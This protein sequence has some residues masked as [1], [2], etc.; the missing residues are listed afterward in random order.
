MKHAGRAA[1]AALFGFVFL[2]A[3][4]APPPRVHPRPYGRGK[5][6]LH[7][8]VI[9]PYRFHNTRIRL[10]FDFAKGIV[11]GDVTNT[12]SPKTNSLSVVPFNSVGPVF[13]SVTL[14][15]S[16]VKYHVTSDHLYVRLP[17]PAKAS[18]TLAIEAKYTVKPVRG[19]YFIRPDKYYPNYQP[20]IWSQGEAEDNRFWFP[21]WDEP[22][23]KTPVEQ[24]ITVPSGW[25][26]IANGHLRTYNAA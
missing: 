10:S 12:I 11:Y 17:H 13:H 26:V 2:A 22:N 25:R 4:A 19:I 6:Y 16:P 15:G 3:I 14:N 24:I 8:T 18:D 5:A 1:I 21:T 9:A 23:Q 7:K 20:E